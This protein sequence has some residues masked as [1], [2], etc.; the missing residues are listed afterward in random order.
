LNKMI[1]PEPLSLLS[2]ID[3]PARPASMAN[4]F[5]YCRA[6]PQGK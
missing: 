4:K 2:R 1:Q 6:S 3:S 5:G